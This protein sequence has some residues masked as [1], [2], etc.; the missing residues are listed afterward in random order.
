LPDL[1]SF[2]GGQASESAQCLQTPGL[3]VLNMTR[4]KLMQLS[5]AAVV[6]VAAGCA[7]SYDEPAAAASEGDEASPQEITHGR[8]SEGQLLQ[9]LAS[10]DTAEIQ[11]AQVALTKATSPQVR[12]FASDMIEQHSRAKLSGE[13]FAKQNGLVLHSSPTSQKLE[14]DANEMLAKLQRTDVRHFDDTYVQAQLDQHAEVL[15]LLDTKWIPAA[16]SALLGQHLKDARVM[17]RH[18]LTH[19]QELRDTVPPADYQMPVS[20]VAE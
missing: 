5:M 4:S 1:R 10:V 3:E 9:L 8:L 16:P 11:Q 13:A 6:A 17:V 20:S 7:K 18:H 15:S 2:G 14:R 19:A 12:N